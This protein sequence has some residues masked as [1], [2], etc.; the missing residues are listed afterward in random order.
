MMMNLSNL[1]A[2]ELKLEATPLMKL[3]VMSVP[4]HIVVVQGPVEGLSTGLKSRGFTGKSVVSRKESYSILA[5]SPLFASRIEH[6]LVC[7]FAVTVFTGLTD[8]RSVLMG[9]GG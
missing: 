4:D 9:S 2:G 5:V 6:C 3:M 7:V 1:V 8:Y